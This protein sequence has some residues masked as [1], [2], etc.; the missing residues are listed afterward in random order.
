MTIMAGE[1]GKKKDRLLFI[2]R[3]LIANTDD[4]HRISQQELAELCAES[5][6]GSDR[7]AISNDVRVLCSYGFDIIRTK[8]G[9]KTY[10]NYGCR[11]FDTAELRT[12]M[13]AV[14][15]S[16]FIS[17]R[18]TEQ[19]IEK[20]AGLLSVHDAEKLRATVYTG[21][22]PKAENNRI[23][24]NIDVINRAINEGKKIAFQ[25]F[26]YDGHRKQIMR[27]NGEIY[28][29]SPWI[30]IWKNDRYYL[31]GW[32][33]N[34]SAIRSFR[35]DRMA[36]PKLLDETAVPRT[37]DF[38]PY[39]FYSTLTR[40]FG[41]GPEMDISLICD[42]AVMNSIVDRFGEDFEFS[43]ADDS[44]FRAAVHVNASG[45]FFGWLFGYG[46][47]IRIEGPEKAKKMYHDRLALAM[48]D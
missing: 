33:D 2:L 18:R 5:G 9:V 27:N 31:V 16:A 8:T 40:M 38:D 43:R 10:Y 6:H 37:D 20:I 48:E 26:T 39:D 17:P 21:K 42:D 30:T 28:T 41:E 19:L 36:L 45:T 29:V 12:L 44:H 34:R 1:R 3:Y 46:G 23:F 11:D 24:L 47:Q 15:S 4:E 7:H 25:H 13:D 14:E 22:V 35:I 32:A